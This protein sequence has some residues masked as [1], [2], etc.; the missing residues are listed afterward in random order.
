VSRTD[1]ITELET[2]RIAQELIAVE[3]VA[4]LRGIDAQLKA[5]RAELHSR[6]N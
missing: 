1:L 5:L 4:R 3:V 2:E 6:E